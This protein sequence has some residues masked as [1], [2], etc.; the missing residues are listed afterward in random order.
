MNEWLAQVELIVLVGTSCAVGITQNVIETAIQRAC[1][2]INFNLIPLFE[3]LQQMSARG[4]LSHYHIDRWSN[5]QLQV[6]DIL[7]PCNSTLP[8]VVHSLTNIGTSRHE[9]GTP[10][11]HDCGSSVSGPTN[12]TYL[13]RLVDKEGYLHKL[14]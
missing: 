13:N 1:P 5:A 6:H 10:C 14:I 3:S 7:G 11:R 8:E 4:E 9:C 2:I 12:P